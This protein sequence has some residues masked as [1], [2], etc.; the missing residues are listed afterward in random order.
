MKMTPGPWSIDDTD[1]S[2][3]E[4]YIPDDIGRYVIADIDA[5][6]DDPWKSQQKA[7]AL[8]ISKAPELLEALKLVMCSLPKQDSYNDYLSPVIREEAEALLAELEKG[9]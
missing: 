3:I 8:V 1:R 2:R 6:F 9:A 7:N 4:I 5:D